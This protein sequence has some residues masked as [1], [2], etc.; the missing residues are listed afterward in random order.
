MLNNGTIRQHFNKDAKLQNDDVIFS[1]FEL[2]GDTIE[3]SEGEP[4]KRLIGINNYDYDY[5][6]DQIFLNS[7][8]ITFNS[9]TEN[10]TIS[11]FQNTIL[12]AGN[13]LK[14]ITNHST[15][16]ESSNIY[17]GPIDP[18][19]VQK[20]TTLRNQISKPKFWSEYHFIEDNGQKT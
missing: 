15:T 6:D 8:K 10:T 11:S 9:K 3:D 5:V 7:K 2:A 17:S 4:P 1:P 13:E 19:S 16:I 18:V 20:L 14:I 12:G